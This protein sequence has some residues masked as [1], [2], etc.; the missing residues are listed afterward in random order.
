MFVRRS[1]NPHIDILPLVR[2]ATGNKLV[3]QMGSHS[4]NAHHTSYQL[5]HLYACLGQWIVFPARI[6]FTAMTV[7]TN[8]EEDKI[9]AHSQNSTIIGL[10]DFDIWGI[11]VLIVL[12]LSKTR[13]T[14]GGLDFQARDQYALMA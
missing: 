9:S 5:L 13:E 11:W 2:G 1:E 7:A 14:A 3:A 10:I 4:V 8:S 6:D 12:V